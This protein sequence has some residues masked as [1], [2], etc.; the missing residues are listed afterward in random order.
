MSLTLDNLHNQSLWLHTAIFN[1]N[2]N[3]W[4]DHDLPNNIIECRICKKTKI[5]DNLTNLSDHN[6]RCDVR[7]IIFR[8]NNLYPFLVHPTNNVRT[9]ITN[10]M[11][12]IIKQSSLIILACIEVILRICW[13][14][15]EHNKLICSSCSQQRNND[16][17]ALILGHDENCIFKLL[18]DTFRYLRPCLIISPI[19][20]NSQNRAPPPPVD[21]MVNA[22]YSINPDHFLNL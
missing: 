14:T 7:I 3:V 12:K 13:K 22:A 5:R 9:Q 10:D 1:I 17:L 2:K 16:E 19:V 21:G 4:V 6:D 18:F 20:N 8:Y 15:Y 11:L